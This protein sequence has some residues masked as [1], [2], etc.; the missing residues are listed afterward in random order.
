[1]ES[2]LVLSY[3]ITSLAARSWLETWWVVQKKRWQ[4]ESHHLSRRTTEKLCE[5]ITPAVLFAP[6]RTS[7]LWIAVS[8]RFSYILTHITV[9]KVNLRWKKSLTSWGLH[10]QDLLCPIDSKL[11]IRMTTETA[12]NMTLR[13][14]EWG[15]TITRDRLVRGDRRGGER[16]PLWPSSRPLSPA[17]PWLTPA[18]QLGSWA[19]SAWADD[20]TSHH[21]PETRIPVNNGVTALYLLR[22]FSLWLER[23]TILKRRSEKAL[24]GVAL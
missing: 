20:T 14:R 7:L 13:R 9:G 10:V 17:P 24:W 18:S 1:M 4:H 22:L 21:K 15:G 3:A 19:L 11:H 12:E 8:T 5:L 6:L 2:V 16:R 23:M